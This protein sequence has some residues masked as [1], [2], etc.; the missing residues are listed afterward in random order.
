MKLN[1]ALSAQWYCIS[2]VV[3]CT[4]VYY[5]SCYMYKYIYIYMYC[6][7]CSLVQQS[8]DSSGTTDD[9]FRKVRAHHSCYIFSQ[10]HLTFGIVI[11]ICD[12]VY[13]INHNSIA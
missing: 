12:F 3:T 9:L 6:V 10:H 11:T 5:I 4:Y 7:C 13:M 2:L 8:P 1:G